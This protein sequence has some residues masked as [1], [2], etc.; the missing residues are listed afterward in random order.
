MAEACVKTVM[1]A[2]IYWIQGP[3]P[4]SLGIVPRPRGGDW[5]EDEVQSWRAAGLDII[6]SLLTPGEIE[7]LDLQQEK[8]L[9]L[10]QGIQFQSF[11]IQDRG[12]PPSRE[13][14]A[15]LVKSLEKALRDGKNVAVHCRQGIGRSSLA[16]ASVLVSAGERPYDAWRK[17]ENSRG[18]PVPDT[19]EQVQW[20][21]K[22]ASAFSS[23]GQFK[24]WIKAH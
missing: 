2:K 21:V 13:S 22:F 3:W 5:L 16:A 8:A 7:E 15:A 14:M 6:V 24:Q 4:G 19:P 18:C 11:P 12:V 9:C 20:V 17:I 23:A 1:R 10:E